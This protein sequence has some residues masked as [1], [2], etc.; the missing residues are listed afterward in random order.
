MALKIY[1]YGPM[2]PSVAR[3]NHTIAFVMLNVLKE[4]PSAVSY[5]EKATVILERVLGMDHPETITAY[6]QL[7]QYYEL[8]GEGTKARALLCHARK[9][10]SLAFG[11]T[12]PE[13]AVIDTQIATSLVKAGN[14]VMALELLGRV[15]ATHSR[16]RGQ[17]SISVA[18]AHTLRAKISQV[19]GNLR[20]AVVCAKQAYTT[21]VAAV[22]ESD[23]RSTESF[24]LLNRLTTDAVHLAKAAQNHVPKKNKP[25]KR[26]GQQRS[27]NSK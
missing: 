7:G 2:H 26:N 5:Q 12:H 20:G 21:Y 27:T 15:V 1:R 19:A 13:H 4:P 10:C 8:A 24:A 18:G 9:L 14:T 22:G 16:F 23:R 25:R 6:I 11:P 17:N 3:C